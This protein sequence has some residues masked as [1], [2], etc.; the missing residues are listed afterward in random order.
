M[1]EKNA[2]GLVV[3]YGL[4]QVPDVVVKA[5]SDCQKAYVIDMEGPMLEMATD[6]MIPAGT[7]IPDV[8]LINDEAFGTS[9]TGKVS[10][11]LVKKEDNG[12]TT[13][14]TLLDEEGYS[15]L[16]SGAVIVPA[17]DDSGDTPVFTGG[18]IVPYDCLVK[19]TVK[20]T[21]SFSAKGKARL[22]LSAITSA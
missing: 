1:A 10:V 12:A 19:V 8:V 17:Y 6:L 21:T 22:I 4:E 9:D 11:A 7:Y 3:R 16:N 2:D 14:K 5:A 20:D 18:F 15:T 13:F